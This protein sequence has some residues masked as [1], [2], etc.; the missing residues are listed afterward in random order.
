M[1]GVADKITY[2]PQSTWP[3]W[4]VP[5]RM[6]MF[7]HKFKHPMSTPHYFSLP[8]ILSFTHIVI[9]VTTYNNKYIHIYISVSK[10]VVRWYVHH[11]SRNSSILFYLFWLCC[12]SNWAIPS[13]IFTAAKAICYLSHLHLR[14]VS[15]PFTNGPKEALRQ[16][17][18]QMNH[19][20]L[21]R[22]NEGTDGFDGFW[23]NYNDWIMAWGEFQQPSL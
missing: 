3:K 7:S 14:S 20:R 13:S 8:L 6:W 12:T 21:P 22:K 23:Y 16:H 19:L 17:A 1:S 2:Y 18:L 11:I 9:L 10:M 5:Y 15:L 4:V